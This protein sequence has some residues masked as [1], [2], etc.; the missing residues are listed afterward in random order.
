MFSHRQSWIQPYGT[1]QTTSQHIYQLSVLRRI[2]GHP[3]TTLSSTCELSRPDTT[4]AAFQLVDEFGIQRTSSASAFSG[5]IRL[6]SVPGSEQ[7][8][9]RL[10][11]VIEGD[12]ELIPSPI[13]TCQVPVE[14]SAGSESEEELNDIAEHELEDDFDPHFHREGQATPM[15]DIAGPASESQHQQPPAFSRWV[16]K[17]RRKRHNHP[18]LLSPRKERWTLDDFDTRAAS[19]GQQYLS[20]GRHYHSDSQGSSVRFVTAVRSATATLAS[21]SMATLSRRTTRFRRGHQRSSIVSGS[22]IRLSIESRRSIIDEAAK[23]RARKRR[24]KLEE[25]IRTEESYVADVKALS[26]VRILSLSLITK[27]DNAGCSQAYFTILAH[28]PTATSF[29]R[30]STQRTIADILHLHDDILGCLHRIVPFAEYDQT[31]ARLPLPL[32]A[33]NRWHSMDAVPQRTTPNRSTL[34]TIRQG[35]RSLNISRSS[36][37]DAQVVLR[38]SPQT[39]AAVAKAFSDNM[40]RFAAYEDYGANYDLIQRDVD[41]TQ[42]AIS[43]WAD[44]DKAIEA[45]SAHVNPMRTREANRK[46]AMTV[47]DLLIKPIQRL[48]RYEL[49]FSDLHKLTP[50][51]DD[52]ISHAEIEELRLKLNSVCHRMNAAKENPARARALE[53]TWLIGDRLTFS[54][55]V[56]RS[57]FLQLLGRVSLCGSLY[58]AYRSRDRI[59]G[60]YVI[61]VLF[62]SCLL[63]A[64]C[65]EDQ[66]KYSILVSITLA[67]AT[68][69]D[70]DNA[71][72]LQC[73][74][75][76]HAW[77]VVFEQGARM[78]E[79]IFTAC[80]AVESE[81]WRTHIASGIETQIAAVAEGKANVFELQSPL[82]ADMKS[83]GKAFGKPG[84]FVRRMSV[85]RAATIGPTADLNQVIIKN[86]QAVK[87]VM[88]NSSQGSFQIPRSQS[89]AT[90]SHVQTLAPRRADRHRL[91]TILSDVWSRDVLP[92]PGMV[93]RSDPIRAGANHV[94]RK[95]SMAS[96]TSNFSSSKRTGSYTSMSSWRKEDMPPPRNRG[97]SGREG[98][99][100]SSRQSRPPLIDFH[101]APDA[102][103]PADFEIGRPSK[104]KRKRSALRTFTM[105]MERPFTPLLGNENK[106]SGLKRAQSVKDVVDDQAR[107]GP[108]PIQA[109]RREEKRVGTPVYSV[110]QERARTPAMLHVKDESLEMGMGVGEASNGAVAGKAPRK[111]KSRLLRLFGQER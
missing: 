27:A 38:C 47:K 41:D 33:H 46:R 17:L 20:P 6:D 98:S 3:F 7:T 18:Q 16:S 13:Q 80:S 82:T 99:S 4:R 39:I 25:L 109:K 58:I 55:Q 95:F 68:I 78:Y 11:D 75:A 100:M 86:T 97:E 32:R 29:A 23:Q 22:E 21:A 24:E 62:E 30:T 71:K 83:I 67:N 45:I 111:S 102:F 84:S 106:Q 81:V 66:S 92:Y 52:P 70:T 105:T 2:L 19:P 5:R 34:A 93:R 88:D 54:S 60:A 14:L 94:I 36:S 43:G 50:A 9:A 28:Q 90:P 87:E 72:G 101:T 65:D 51:C 103:L 61:C 57:I 56:P 108:S 26:N 110:V 96:I 49:L 40:L 85:Q 48:P 63:L 74:T 76:P 89:V 77:K 37:D 73:H 35:R 91:E 107:P 8:E 59:K 44:F 12:D 104:D 69:E 64:S 79:L 1:A 42:R 10:G 31:I 15:V 53:M